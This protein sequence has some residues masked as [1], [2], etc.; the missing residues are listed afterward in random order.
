MEDREVSILILRGSANE[1]G[2]FLDLDGDRR[3][4]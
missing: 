4:N 2:R 3:L 1:S